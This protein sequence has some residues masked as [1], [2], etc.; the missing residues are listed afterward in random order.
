MNRPEYM[1]LPS[2]IIPQEIMEQYNL[3]TKINDGWVYVRI[4]KGMY[5]L[6][7]AGILANKLLSN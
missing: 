5:R 4:D 7:Q 1:R 2:K 3:Q 6:P